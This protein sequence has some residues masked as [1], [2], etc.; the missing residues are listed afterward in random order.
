MPDLSIAAVADALH[1]SS[2]DV[3]TVLVDTE[4]DPL[5]AWAVDDVHQTLNPNGERTVPEWHQPD[6]LTGEWL[7][8]GPA[9]TDPRVV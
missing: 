9:I 6:A 8:L 1:V 7:R 4:D 3:R 5:P 2:E